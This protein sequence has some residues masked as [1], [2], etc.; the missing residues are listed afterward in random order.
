[1][2]IFLERLPD[3][4]ESVPEGPVETDSLR[5]AW[6]YNKLEDI[7]RTTIS[8][9][10]LG[11]HFDLS[12]T[13]NSAERIQERD[14][15]VATFSPDSSESLTKNL[16]NFILSLQKFLTSKCS[17]NIQRIGLRSRIHHYAD[18][19]YTITGFDGPT[20]KNTAYSDFDGLFTVTKLPWLGDGLEP[21]S[22]PLTMDWA[23]KVKRRQFLLQV[24]RFL[25]SFPLFIAHI[26][27]TSVPF[28]LLIILV[29]KSGFFCKHQKFLRYP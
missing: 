10:Y 8:T 7:D 2:M 22:R 13:M 1:M 6:R 17:S 3:V 18:Y 20:G 19:A 12:S 25:Y 11:H 28:I 21:I 5:I 29:A 14:L 24:T 4:I 23:F 26:L 9:P 27:A 16:S 15:E